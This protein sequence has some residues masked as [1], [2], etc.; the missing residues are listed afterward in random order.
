MATR[1]IHNSI[2]GE[3]RTARADDTF[4]LYARARD[5][6]HSRTERHMG[7]LARMR[8]AMARFGFKPSGDGSWVAASLKARFDPDPDDLRLPQ[9]GILTVRDGD[10]EYRFVCAWS[11]ELGRAARMT[12]R[13]PGTVAWLAS[14]IRDGDVVYDVGANIGIYTLF[15]GA[16]VG[17]GGHV[18]AF[19]PH[20]GNV[21]SL[22]RNVVASGLLDRVTVLSCPLA[23]APRV[24]DF[25]YHDL[26]PSA[27]LGRLGEDARVQRGEGA[28]VCA[29]RKLV[30]SVDEL[31]ER[32][33]IPTPD[34]VKV[35]VEG[36]ETGVLR[37]MESVLKSAARPRSVQVEIDG[38][39][40]AVIEQFMAACGFALDHKHR[41]GPAQRLV[42]EGR[43]PG[44][45]VRNAVFVP[46]D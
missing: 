1:K 19:E 8:K 36:N 38:E 15:A 27:G 33:A 18:Y 34:L 23:E 12:K 46:R 11:G 45:V 28:G 16:R 4:T 2:R 13:E 43:E 31:V 24:A 37:G 10:S 25:W 21:E 35:D 42:D 17:S 30:A 39:T 3:K 41:S 29:E 22:L 6:A 40:A 44:E 32:G 26:A 5:W 9:P 7:P 20:A 14:Q